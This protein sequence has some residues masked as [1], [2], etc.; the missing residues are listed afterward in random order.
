MFK[1]KPFI[2]L[3][4]VV[5][6]ILIGLSDLPS[7]IDEKSTGP[8]EKV[9]QVAIEKPSLQNKYQSCLSARNSRPE[10]PK[11]KTQMTSRITSPSFSGKMVNYFILIF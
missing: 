10:D 1:M 7:G 9:V 3:T 11:E 4:S 6:L 2:L 8:K 5:V